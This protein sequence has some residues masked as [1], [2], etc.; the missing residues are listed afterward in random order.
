MKRAFAVLGSPRSESQTG[1]ALQA[2]LS[3]VRRAGGATELYSLRGKTVSPCLS[4]YACAKTGLCHLQ[5]NMQDIYAEFAKADVIILASPLYFL[6]LSAQ[7]KA[8]VDRGQVC[9]CRSQDLN[10]DPLEPVKTRKGFF[11]ATGGAPNRPGN[12]FDPAVATVKLFFSALKAEYAGEYLIADTD[13][14]PVETRTALLKELEQI[15]YDLI[16]GMNTL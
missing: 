14:S 7:L 2:L 11:L 15:G 13:D 10:L 9:F 16:E 12:N 3:G 1:I 5:D 8:V 4:C 6:G